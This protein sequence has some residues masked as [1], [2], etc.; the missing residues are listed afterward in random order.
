MLTGSVISMAAPI[1]VAIDQDAA[2][3]S[4]AHVA[5]G[6]LLRPLH[7]ASKRQPRGMANHQWLVARSQRDT[8]QLVAVEINFQVERLMVFG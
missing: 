6:N 5:E 8:P 2:H 4:I 3:A 7:A 1:V